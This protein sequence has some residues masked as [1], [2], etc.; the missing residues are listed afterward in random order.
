M[1]E[2][3]KKVGEAGEKIVEEFFEK[4]GWSDSQKNLSINCAKQPKHGDKGK[5]RKTHG[6]D[7]LFSYKSSLIDRILEHLIISS[8]FTD[9][10]YPA[11]PITK[12]KEHFKDLA[13]TIECFKGSHECQELNNSFS[14]VE[15][16]HHTGVLFWLSNDKNSYDDLISKVSGSQ[17]SGKFSYESIY[18]VDNHRVAF[19]Y[20]T[21]TYIE[22]K[23]PGAEFDFFYPA[24]GK[25]ND[26]YNLESGGDI[27]PVQYINTSVLPIKLNI[28][29]NLSLLIPGVI[30]VRK[31]H[32]IPVPCS[33][34]DWQKQ[35]GSGNAWD[36]R[37]SDLTTWHL[38]SEVPLQAKETPLLF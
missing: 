14:G 4:I 21:I 16:A 13:Q 35:A 34:T 22:K 8:K 5:K 7:F 18:L 9:K 29:N 28:N 17:I 19:L 27:L 23:Y 32:S 15:G 11:N 6:I 24:T 36:Y 30:W 12:F 1:G 3:S 31:V 37:I 25:N 26:P 38:L 33:M 2:W 10:E 20:D